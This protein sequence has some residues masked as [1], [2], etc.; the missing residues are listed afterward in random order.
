MSEF[1]LQGLASQR[2]R[3]EQLVGQFRPEL[4]RYCARMMGAA[5]DGE[6]VLQEALAKAFYQLGSSASVPALKPWLLRITHHTALD[7]L[8]RYERRHSEPLEE[9]AEGL[10]D[11]SPDL[12]STRS[13]L[14]SFLFLPV[15]HRS[16]VILKD[17]LGLTHEEIASALRVS[18]PAVK[19]G[20]VRGRRALREAEATEPEARPLSDELR[21]TLHAYVARFNARD[22]DGLRALL[23][24]EVELELVGKAHRRGA[25][26]SHY[27]GNY[28]KL[29]A[30][31]EGAVA[32]TLGLADGRPAL[33]VFSAPTPTRL[34]NVVLLEAGPTGI[35]FIRDFRYLPTFA[36][37]VSFL[38]V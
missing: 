28:A 10:A 1:E 23:A 33:G 3:F 27:F 2:E 35:H 31:P 7:H 20:L 29:C 15:M 6:D 38:P 9:H 19:S 12:A 16:V 4:H 26:V 13:A 11:E 30:T 25:E 34:V 32:L 22:W 36:D 37:A 5:I 14:S 18:V 8:K 21:A 24:K 17:V